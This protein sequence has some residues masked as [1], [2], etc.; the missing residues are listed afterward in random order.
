MISEINFDDFEPEVISFANEVPN[1]TYVRPRNLTSGNSAHFLLWFPSNFLIFYHFLRVIH[2]KN[3]FKL[4]H[5]YSGLFVSF[6]LATIE[7]NLLLQSRSLWWIE[8]AHCLLTILIIHLRVLVSVLRKYNILKKWQ[9]LSRILKHIKCTESTKKGHGEQNC[10][11]VRLVIWIFSP[12]K[13]LPSSK[14]LGV[15]I[16]Q[17]L[18]SYTPYTISKFSLTLTL[19]TDEVLI[20]YSNCRTDIW[21]L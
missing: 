2:T 15:W 14:I 9:I 21:I 6:D 20:K 3:Y 7:I 10:L 4:T 5:T 8:F 19:G 17:P 12:A 1:S 13:L 18:L 16:N 11:K